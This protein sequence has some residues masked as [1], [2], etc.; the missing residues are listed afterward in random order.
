MASPSLLRRTYDATYGRLFARIY[1]R[2]LARAEHGEQGARRGALVSRARGRILELGAGTGLNLP[3]YGEEIGE[4]VLTEPF[5][6]MARRLR[7]RVVEL[8]LEAE[9][10]EAPAERLPLDDDSF[11]T[12]VCTLMLCTVD[13]QAAAL[14]EA[15][16]VLRP[17]GT[18][19]AFEHV[20][21]ESPRLARAQD[22]LHGP[23]YTV[24][25]G[26]HCNRD[27]LAALERSGLEIDSLERF[28]LPSA[29]PIV[30]PMITAVARLP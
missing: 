15:E 18:L 20:R 7:S 17:G 14:A 2:A 28:E 13:D 16:R 1:D 30:R 29:P 6:P 4:L 21:S 19:L 22:I 10:V 24:G 3:H 5:E 9:V 26:C 27:T 8:G 12:V 25:H 23:W 11:D